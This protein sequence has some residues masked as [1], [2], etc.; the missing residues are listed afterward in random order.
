M[1]LSTNRTGRGVR[2]SEPLLAGEG[3]LAQER[4]RLLHEFFATA[5]SRYPD[6]VA[7]DVPPGEGRA[8]RR[9]LTYRQ[10]DAQ[11]LRLAH[12]LEPHL[13]DESIV[14]LMLPR[15]MEQLYVSQ[16]AVLRAGAAYCCIDLSFPDERVSYILSDSQAVLLLTDR[17]GVERAAALGIEKT[18]VL[19]IE[20]VLEAESA[21][22][23][24]ALQRPLSS[25][26]LAYQVYTS[27]T[28][29][30][31]KGVMIEHG[32]ICNL[33][34][35]NLDCFLLAPEDRVTQSSSPAWDSSV[36][37]IWLA[38]SVGATLVVMD[39]QVARSGPDIIHWLR[40]ERITVFISVPTQLQSTGC[41]NPAAQ[42]PELR[43]LYVGGE[44]LPQD[45]ADLWAR[46]CRL[47]NGYGPTETTV[48]SVRS[49]VK[50]GEPVAIGRPVPRMQ[51]WVLDEALVEVEDGAQ[52][53]LFIG[54]IGLARGYRNSPELTRSRFPQHPRFGR[55]HRT[56]DA[57]S[58]GPGGELFF[59]GRLDSQ[60]KIRG[61]RIELREI[62]SR[63]AELEGVLEAACVARASRGRTELIAFVVASDPGDPPK[64]NHLREQL[65]HSLP[66]YMVPLRIGFLPQLPT[67]VSGKLDRKRLPDLPVD[68]ASVERELKGPQNELEAT[69]VSAFQEGLGYSD[70]ISTEENFFLDLGG[71]SLGAALVL[72]IL[73]DAPVTSSL[74]VRDLYETAT[75]AGLAK[76][77]EEKT[78]PVA[79]ADFGPVAEVAQR[80]RPLA[81]TAI[82]TAFIALLLVGGSSAAYL[83]AFTL[84]PRL[85]AAWGWTLFF[86]LLPLLGFALALTYLPLSVLALAATK[87]LLIGKY[88]PMK[89]P[90]W[91]A[92]YA[93]H[94]IVQTVGKMVPWNFAAGTVFPSW[95]LRM[96]GAKVGR[97]VHFHRGVGFSDGGWDL[98]EIGD[99]VTLSQEVALRLTQLSDGYLHVGPIRIG[100]S[101]TLE[102]RSGMAGFT[103]IEEGGYLGPLASLAPGSTI[104]THE[105]W[106]GVPAERSARSPDPVALD[107]DAAELSPCRSTAAIRSR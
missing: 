53:E 59:H 60:V 72:S 96:L 62:E 104:G 6:R 68:A 31:P 43:Y 7:V 106:D 91:S 67:S 105:R 69:I 54:G 34:E 89:I 39:E 83:I 23:G 28:T 14:A 55:I 97:R 81:I 3:R 33:V 51:A 80:R 94:W 35:G 99:D 2:D 58:R 64:E 74:T 84:L 71:D 90:V 25:S 46:C 15:G 22:A 98:L 44:A 4:P 75:A 48:V 20:Q 73:R 77:A 17:H 92:T 86:L 37:E 42:L 102:R 47:F 93:R 1:T 61:Y 85:V 82:Q 11:S 65:R 63:L 5:A 30:Q 26:T 40:R 66:E 45:L 76:R 27:G 18:Q 95:A 100:N 13:D 87:R 38:L 79:A 8:A 52:G 21:A 88:R 107:G 32:S 57:V 50:Q 9:Q 12:L 36:E 29:G 49:E 10:L 78:G 70:P 56:G 101:A 41:R 19:D 24:V 103:T 16:L